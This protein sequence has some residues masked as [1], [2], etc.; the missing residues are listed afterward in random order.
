MFRSHRSIE[1]TCRVQDGRRRQAGGLHDPLGQ[2]AGQERVVLGDRDRNGDGPRPVHIPPTPT[3]QN[4]R[5]C[6]V[7]V[8][9]IELS[10]VLSV[11]SLL[12]LDASDPPGKATSRVPNPPCGGTHHHRDGQQHQ[13]IRRDFESHLVEHVL[14][15]EP[16]APHAGDNQSRNDLPSLPH[17]ERP[18]LFVQIH[19]RRRSHILTIWVSTT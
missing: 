13:C 18:P 2:H 15:V 1:C 5:T 9:T 19:F 11:S 7:A 8:Q 6:E 16:K 4:A 14:A 10:Q 17:A 12:W 3:P